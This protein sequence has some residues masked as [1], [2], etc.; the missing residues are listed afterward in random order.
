MILG[1]CLIFCVNYV[2]RKFKRCFSRAQ[3]FLRSHSSGKSTMEKLNY[4]QISVFLCGFGAKVGG[5][6]S[7]ARFQQQHPRK[8]PRGW[9]EGQVGSHL[10]PP[11]T[12]VHTKGE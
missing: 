1:L 12:T 7:I 11:Q 5:G 6:G 4:T 9:S 8:P 10:L 2:Q 3:Q